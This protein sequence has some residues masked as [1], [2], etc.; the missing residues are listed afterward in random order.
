[1]TIAPGKRLT[2]TRTFTDNDIDVF[3]AVSGDTGVHHMQADPDG[4]RM[5]QGL[6]T[7]SLSTKIGGDLDYIAATMT[8]NFRRPVWSG[9]TITTTATVLST[10]TESSRLWCDIEFDSTNQ[11]GTIVLTGVTSG[12]I[13]H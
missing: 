2:Y 12:F 5:V 13:A 6:L 10:R 7:A 9:D 4:R 1:M 3:A 8:F 11:D